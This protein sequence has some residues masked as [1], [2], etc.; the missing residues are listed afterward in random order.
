MAHNYA[1]KGT[2]FVCITYMASIMIASPTVCVSAAEK[3]LN[4]CSDVVIPSLF[5]FIFCGNM[6]I[7][8]GAARIMEKTFSKIMRP[9]FGVSG[10]GALAFVLGIV[11]GY[12]VGAIC[13]SS[14]YQAGEISRQDAEKLLVFCNNSG[15]MFII[16]GI[17]IKMFENYKLGVLIYAVNILS[18]IICG[19]IFRNYKISK[20][21]QNVLPPARN[22]SEIKI[23]APDIG[24]AI[25]KSVNSI[26]TICG[27]I[28]IFAVFTAK[29]PDFRWRGYIYSLFEIVGGLNELISVNNNIYIAPIV[30]F[31]TAFS[32]ISVMAQV[33]AVTESSGLSVLP[34][35]LGKIIQGLIAFVLTYILIRLIPFSRETFSSTSLSGV[36]AYTPRQLFALSIITVAF[37]AVSMLIVVIVAKIFDRYEK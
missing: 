24:A 31:A 17:G 19:M 34:Y 37:C 8:L 25:V 29:I 27:F 5:P 15:P 30:A 7:A 6:F 1:L 33:Y 18:A 10:A 2:I 13:A 23:A 20:V 14:L 12:P 4:V 22:E 32:G 3:A 9:F 26:L 21:K 28:I 35:I 11:S 16:G 36:S